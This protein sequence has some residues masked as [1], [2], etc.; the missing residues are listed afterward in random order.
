MIAVVELQCPIRGECR[1]EPVVIGVDIGDLDAARVENIEAEPQARG[2][3]RAL[4]AA[5]CVT[6]RL[7]RA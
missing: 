1:E 5:L 4:T 3:S 6:P 7:G 2:R